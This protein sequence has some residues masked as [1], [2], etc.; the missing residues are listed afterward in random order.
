MW[1]ETVPHQSWTTF[2]LLGLVL[3]DI[4]QGRFIRISA[5]CCQRKPCTHLMHVQPCTYLMPV[6]SGVSCLC[7]RQ[8]IT[9]VTGSGGW[10]VH[11]EDGVRG[12]GPGSLAEN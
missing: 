1:A 10:Y 5:I 9:G 11:L 3:R 4:I 12:A 7:V 6:Q 2:T 8:G